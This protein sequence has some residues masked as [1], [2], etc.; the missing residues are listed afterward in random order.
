M[1]CIMVAGRQYSQWN[2]VIRK[3]IALLRP[4]HHNFDLSSG[5]TVSLADKAVDGNMNTFTNTGLPDNNEAETDFHIEIEAGYLITEV[6][7]FN[8]VDAFVERLKHFTIYVKNNDVEQSVLFSRTFT[9][10]PP[11]GVVHLN[12]ID[13]NEEFVSSEGLKVGMSINNIGS[14]LGFPHMIGEFQVFGKPM[15]DVDKSFDFH[16]GDLFPEIGSQI[17]YV[18]LLQDNDARQ[19]QGR[20]KFSNIEIYERLDSDNIYSRP[21]VCTLHLISICQLALE[22]IALTTNPHQ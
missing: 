15:H 11:N 5:S 16:I 7:I 22:P 8:R 20:S 3:N 21:M 14:E 18:V 4:A 12:D 13:I 6:K 10:I 2:H 17:S 19:F 1:R 9:E